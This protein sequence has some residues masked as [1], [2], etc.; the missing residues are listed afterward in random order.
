[1]IVLTADASPERAER[2]LDLGADAHIL[3]PADVS[4]FLAAVD[5]L[6]LQRPLVSP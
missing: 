2:L 4:S 5:A 3:K 6:L 1:V